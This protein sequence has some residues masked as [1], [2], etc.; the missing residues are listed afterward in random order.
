ME[1]KNC[2]YVLDGYTVKRLQDNF[3]CTNHSKLVFSLSLIY[4]SL[5]KDSF[6]LRWIYQQVNYLKFGDFSLTENQNQ[7]GTQMNVQETQGN[8]IKLIVLFVQCF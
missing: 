7:N 1:R 8:A 4:T 5:T 3:K 2:S 6:G